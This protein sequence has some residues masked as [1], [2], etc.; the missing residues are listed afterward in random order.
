MKIMFVSAANSTH[1]VR[2]VNALAE[3]GHEVYLVSNRGHEPKEDALNSRVKLYL[4]KHS[5]GKGYYL[6]SGEL[7]KI[8]KRIN[9]DVI[10]VHYASGYGTLARKARLPK[11]ILSVWG[12]DVYDFPYESR[13][14]NHI[15]KRNVRS[16]SYLASTSN[17][18]AV[19]LKKVM[20]DE[21]LEITITPFGVDLNKFDPKKYKEI[22]K[23]E[24]IIGN[25]KAL[26]EIY[27]IEEMILA[28]R[29]LKKELEQEHYSRKIKLL[30]YGSGSKKEQYEDLIN[31]QN[32]QDSVFL[33]GKIPNMKVPEAISEFDIFC[34]LSRKESF[35]VAA[36]EAMAMKK[37]VVA[38]DADGFK[39]VIEDGKTG[40]IISRKE[41][42]KA[43]D[44]LKKLVLDEK[45]RTKMGNNGRQRVEQLYSWND[46]VEKMLNLYERVRCDNEH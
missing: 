12:S 29:D 32:L 17:C 30:I 1:T 25:I 8:A 35:G 21:K 31:K 37:P 23:E 7:R 38:S 16:A 19:Q 5:G 40:L 44:A 36:V 33:K 26:E 13:V 15:L 24:L 18:M 28:F 9:P 2:W 10:N 20:Q 3:R 22:E 43:K 41:I 42:N 11:Y 34:A 27:G 14:K 45:M 6:N 4:M 46:N 39:E